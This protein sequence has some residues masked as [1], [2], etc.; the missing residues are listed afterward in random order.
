M[1]DSFVPF[2]G[3]QPLSGLTGGANKGEIKH[4]FEITKKLG[5]GTYGKVSLAY[6]HKTEKEVKIELN[7]ALDHAMNLKPSN[8]TN[9]I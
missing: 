3:G 2:S 5:S 4:R 1:T 7:Y 8:F 9:L 6:D